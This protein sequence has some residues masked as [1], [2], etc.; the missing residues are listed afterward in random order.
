MTTW[1]SIPVSEIKA[2]ERIRLRGAEFDVARVDHPFLG[3]DQMACLIEDTPTRW[4]AHPAGVAEIV[5]AQRA[6]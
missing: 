4:H 2:G 5:E 1:H 6:D 3:M